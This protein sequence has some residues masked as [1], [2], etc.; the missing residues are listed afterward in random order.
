MGAKLAVMAIMEICNGNIQ[1]TEQ[2]DISHACECRNIWEKRHNVEKS[3][4]IK[5]SSLWRMIQEMGQ[6][7]DRKDFSHPAVK[8]QFYPINS[9]D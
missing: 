5:Q 7:E 8:F 4:Y 1:R 9:G 2:L 6:G 3:T